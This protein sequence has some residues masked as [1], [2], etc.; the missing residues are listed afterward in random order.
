ML[1]TP[2]DLAI[3]IGGYNS[4]NTTHLVELCEKKMP[5]Y[6]INGEEQLLSTTHI[7]HFDYH[8]KMELETEG[9]LPKSGTTRI[10]MTSGA[11][12]PDAQVEGVIRKLAKFY[13]Q[14]SALESW[15]TSFENN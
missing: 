8:K 10:L 5:A 14:E 9:Y 7:R 1:E 4:S 6:F 15:I 2:A 11:S 3:V 12:C 13:N